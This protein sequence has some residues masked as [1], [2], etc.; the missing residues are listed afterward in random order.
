MPVQSAKSVIAGATPG[1][2]IAPNKDDGKGKSKAQF[3]LASIK[4]EQRLG[5]AKGSPLNS[6]KALDKAGRALDNGRT[7]ETGRTP[8]DGRRLDAG[9]K[10]ET[11]RTLEKG[12]T[13]LGKFLLPVL[14]E[15]AKGGKEVS[16][17]QRALTAL[18]YNGCKAD[19]KFGPKTAESVRCFQ[20][21]QGLKRDGV[22][23][24]RE[25][26]P[27]M[28]KAL[29]IRH[30][31]LTRLGDAMANNR[32]ISQPMGAELKQL[33]TILGEFSNSSTV[34]T[35]DD[36]PLNIASPVRTR[37]DAPLNIA[38]P[39]RTRDDTPAPTLSSRPS[40]EMVYVNRAAETLTDVGRLFG[41]PLATLIASNPD[42]EKPYLILPGQ[43]IVIPKLIKDRLFRKLPR[44]LHP[45]D[46]EGY[47]AGSN[48]NTDFVAKVNAMVEQLR[49]EGFDVRVMAGFRTFREQQERFE[50]GRT[51]SGSIVTDYEAGHSWH[52]YG[53]AVDMALND[54]E[55]NPAWPEE[56][57]PYWQR[58]GDV[59]MT[60]GVV[61][62]GAFGFPGHIEYHPGYR[63]DEAADFIEDFESYGL[64]AVWEAIALEMPDQV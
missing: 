15:G 58:L 48:M 51:A 59:A 40:G 41:L 16:L 50:Q 42:I 25:T 2:A 47:L 27:A 4:T 43:E 8:G 53:L 29:T 18:G 5:G 38:S 56:S 11:S 63:T 61:W 55:G 22:V 44:Q 3:D 52:N 14:R 19:G 7:L 60:H 23:G 30:E 31:G 54:D 45:A 46:P 32:Q 64:E 57:S 6:D 28:N 24:N 17:A 37:D 26:W 39:V 49:G 36:A 62:G 34:R 12:M 35:R 20:V 1:Q 13:E 10:S 9:G 21:D 33:N